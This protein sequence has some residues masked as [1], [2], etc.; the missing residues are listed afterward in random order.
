MLNVKK[1]LSSIFILVLSALYFTSCEPFLEN[2]IEES[3]QG[4]S[5]EVARV[6]AAKAYVDAY[7]DDCGCYDDFAEVDLEATDLDINISIHGILCT[8]T[9]EQMDDLFKAVCTEEGRVFPSACV[10]RCQIQTLPVLEGCTLN[11]PTDYLWEGVDCPPSAEF[12]LDLIFDN[13]TT[14]TVGSYEEMYYV[15]LEEFEKDAG[16]FNEN[17][18]NINGMTCFEFNFPLHVQYNNGNSLVIHNHSHFIR[19]LEEWQATGYAP[20]QCPDLVFPYSI[21]YD[22]G[23]KQTINSDA[24]EDAAL[25]RCSDAHEGNIGGNLNLTPIQSLFKR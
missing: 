5:P 19:I 9:P 21:T 11:L 7:G 25:E 18:L 8:Y 13:G 20:Q 10:A 24:M 17:N 4:V 16:T 12:P 6:L 23:T 22:D 1:Q 15:M 14:A 2:M 3:Y